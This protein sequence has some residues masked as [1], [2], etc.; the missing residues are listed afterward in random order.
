M[1]NIHDIYMTA[2]DRI[3]ASFER[4]NFNLIRCSFLRRGQERPNHRDTRGKDTETLGDFPVCVPTDV[5][6][7]DPELLCNVNVLKYNTWRNFLGHQH[8]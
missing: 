7:V 2:F 6:D 1:S 8:I 5:A 3:S 4:L